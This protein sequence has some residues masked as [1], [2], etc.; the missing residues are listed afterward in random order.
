MN[1]LNFVKDQMRIRCHDGVLTERLVQTPA[2]FGLGRLPNSVK[3]DATVNSICGYCA[4]G[5]S[6]KIHLREGTAV[7]LS[8][9]TGYPVNV[10]MACPKGWEALTPL[11]A[12]DRATTPYLRNAAGKLVAVSWSEAMDAFCNRFKAIQ[13]EHGAESVAFLSTGQIVAEEMA[14]LGSLAKFGMGVVHGDGNTRQCMATAATAYKQSF[15]YDSPPY[16]YQD[17]EESDVL[18][19]VGANPCIAHPIMWQRVMRNQRHPE[20]IVVDPRKTETAMAATDYLPLQPKSDLELFY[21]L[22]AHIVE[23]GLVDRA[24]VDAHTNDYDAFAKFLGDYSLLTAAEA[25]GLPIEQLERIALLIASGKRVSFW[26][27]MGVNQSYEGTRLAQS[28]INLALMT[29]NIGKPGTGANSITGQCNAMGSRLFS[30]TTGLLGGRNFESESDRQQVAEILDIPVER[31]PAK[32]S[33]SYCEIIDAIDRGEIKGLWL[34]ATNTAH[35]WINQKRFRKV[36][37]KLDF[38]VVQDMYH[39]TESAEIADLVLPAAGWGEKDGVFINSERRIGITRKVRKAPGEALSDF[40][41]LR[42]IAHHWGCADLFKKWDSPEAVFRILTQLSKGMPCDISGI[43]GYADL[44]ING[45]IQWPYS[46]ELVARSEQ[47]GERIAQQR[48]LFEEGQFYHADGKAKFFFEAPQA[49]PEPANKDYP[50]ILLTGRGTSSQWHTQTRTGKSDVLRKLYPKNPYV[51]ISPVDAGLL[52]IKPNTQV[53]IRSRRG[54][55][56]AT[57]VILSSVQPGQLF[58]P[59]HY[60]VTNHLTADAFDPYSKQPSYKACAVTLLHLKT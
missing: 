13:A 50:L 28:M 10:G 20:I 34:I 37:E 5:C 9:N 22:A 15:G 54:E 31:I 21:G 49:M 23:L 55:V 14:F 38:L 27:T 56:E 25:T 36:R 32:Q 26:W 6:L 11:S 1:V 2:A 17:F 58:M 43:R 39:S 57:A 40:N 7:N 8:A 4:T 44:E 53:R 33:L 41:I 59:M 46:E 12:A 16:T 29:G 42:L 35:S 60:K 18:I 52:G 47:S 48:R 3:P 24:F 51:E 19:F 30:N 45:G